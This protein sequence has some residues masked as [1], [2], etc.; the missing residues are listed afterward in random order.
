MDSELSPGLTRRS[1]H[2][3]KVSFH[4][5]HRARDPLHLLLLV[6]CQICFC[7]AGHALAQDEKLANPATVFPPGESLKYEVKWD[8][9][10]WLFFVPTFSAGQITMQCPKYFQYQDRQAYL[11]SATAISSGFLPKLTGLTVNDYFESMVDAHSFCSL[12]MYKKTQEGKRLREVT[13]T[14][15]PGQT[16]GHLLISDGSKTPPAILK[17][18]EVQHLPG[19]VQDILSVVYHCRLRPL[20]V[21]RSYLVT[22]CE[23][24]AV[25]NLTIFVKQREILNTSAG[26]IRALRIEAISKVGGLFKDG[27]QITIWATDDQ[28]KIPIRYEIKVKLGRVFGDLVKM[29]N[30][31]AAET[32]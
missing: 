7:Q 2:A 4:F 1:R 23:T 29:E 8:P 22:I 17:D 15:T 24:G 32:H 11:F 20:Q 27:G 14:F 3:R 16:T 21:G 26:P 12:R 18:E 9:P 31:A 5:G 19:C 13:Q 10:A 25:K 28:R 6:F 30:T